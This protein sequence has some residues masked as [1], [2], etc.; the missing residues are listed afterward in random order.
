[1]QRSHQAAMLAA[2]A[3]LVNGEWAPLAADLADMD[4]L[5]PHTDRTA[6]TRALEEA[7]AQNVG[8]TGGVG[9]GGGVPNIRFG[10]VSFWG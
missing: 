2:I 9:V 8:T 10:Q 4:V 7:F 6:V 5:K 3:H 1:M